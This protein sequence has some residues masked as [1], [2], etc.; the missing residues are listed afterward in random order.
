MN[1][2][3]LFLATAIGQGQVEEPVML[4]FTADWCPACRTMESTVDRLIQN[5]YPVKRVVVDRNQ[6]LVARFHVVQMP[7]F[8]MVKDGKELGRLV[9][10]TS[11]TRLEQMIRRFRPPTPV[12]VAPVQQRTLSRIP[13]VQTDDQDDS[14]SQLERRLLQATVR[15]EVRD[16]EGRSFGSGTIID[17]RSGYALVLTCGHLFRE[18]AGKGTIVVD[19]FV[20]A[21]RRR[22]PGELIRYDAV[23]HDIALVKI[24]PG[25]ALQPVLV[26]SQAS[27]LKKGAVVFS[28]GCDHGDQPTLKRTHINSLNRYH[29][30]DNI[31]IAGLPPDGRSGGGLFTAEGELIGVCNAADPLDNEGFY[32]SLVNVHTQ[33]QQAGLSFVMNPPGNHAVAVSTAS[34]STPV[35]SNAGVLQV[36][37]RGAGGEEFLLD[38]PSVSSVRAIIEQARSRGGTVPASI[39]QA[40]GLPLPNPVAGAGQPML[41]RGQSND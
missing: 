41:I 39:R 31:Q 24:R 18:S 29:G 23:R 33:L 19:L 12:K 36:I 2:Q 10:A 26:A 1:W 34:H 14:S 32:S 4:E 11:Y 27:V 37:V 16:P 21:T 13:L 35:A 9:G 20:D 5:G 17:A 40:A 15:L 25:V 38:H 28:T 30:P 7:T 8:L 22:V 6:E 3:M